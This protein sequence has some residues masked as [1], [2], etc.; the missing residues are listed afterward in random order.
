[1]I[2]AS[3]YGTA[4]GASVRNVDGS[5]YDFVAERLRGHAARADRGAAGRV[6]R[7]RGGG[8]GGARSRGAGASTP[9]IESIV[10]VQATLD[11]IY[12]L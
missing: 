3:F 12:E 5:F 10:E 7:A 4:G 1:M 8:L 6:G 11:R 9:R 2:E